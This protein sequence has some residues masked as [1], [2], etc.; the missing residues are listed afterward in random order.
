MGDDG[1]VSFM[2]RGGAGD[3]VRFGSRESVRD[4]ELVITTTDNLPPLTACA[5]GN[6]N[7]GDGLIDLTDPGC[8]G[9]GDTSEENAPPPP[10]AACADLVDNDHDGLVDLA[11]PGCSGPSDTDETN[12]PPPPPAACA[13]GTDN[14]GDGEVDFP[15]DPGCTGLTDDDETNALTFGEPLAIA[16]QGYRQ[17][18]RDD[19]SGTV[20]DPAVWTPKEFWEDD[21]R[22]GAV[23]VSDGTV[24]IRNARPYIDDQSITT[25]PSWGADDPVKKAWKFGYFEARMRFTDAKGSWPAFWLISE[26]HATWPNWPACP[27]PDLNFELD[28]MEY[29]GDEPTQFYGTEH[30]N[31]GD[32]C[33]TADNTRSVFTK[34]GKL[35][36]GWHTF[37]VLWTATS[38]TWYVDDV[39][40]GAPQPLWDSGDQ[41][42]FI[43]LTMQACGWDSTNACGSTTPNPLETEVDY[44]DVWQ[45]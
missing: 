6:D 39:Q 5:D 7:D 11:D 23:V 24:K 15:A 40:Q 4:P 32:V 13:D 43:S 35:A 18:F 14:D 10:P 41:R 38:V 44:V 1:T 20:L 25:G 17:V 21:P 3:A 9:P 30:R 26:A 33:G 31:T 27:E 37:S 36:G 45:K 28:I 2:I 12:A 22:P 34:P 16:G 8:W 29:Q 42:M 19:F